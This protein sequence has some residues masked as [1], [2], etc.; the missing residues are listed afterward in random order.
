MVAMAF[1]RLS[2]GTRFIPSSP[3]CAPSHRFVVFLGRMKQWKDLASERRMDK[4]EPRLK[5][6]G[7][8]GILTPNC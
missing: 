2:S 7:H 1:L 5:K 3:A 4:M 8:N 6:L